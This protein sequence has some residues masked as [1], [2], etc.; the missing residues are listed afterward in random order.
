MILNS[1]NTDF[2]KNGAT[3]QAELNK[4]PKVLIYKSD[5]L[6]SSASYAGSAER[7][8]ESEAI[9]PQFAEILKNI[10][11]FVSL[12]TTKDHTEKVQNT[13]AYR[14]AHIYAK[15]LTLDAI[16]RI[17]YIYSYWKQSSTIEF[18]ECSNNR[19]SSYSSLYKITEKKL[20]QNDFKKEP[21][22]SFRI[23]IYNVQ[24][25]VDIINEVISEYID[26]KYEL[27]DE[28]GTYD[29]ITLGRGETLRKLYF[30]RA[31]WYEKKVKSNTCTKSFS[32]V[33][34]I[35]E[36]INKMI[37]KIETIDSMDDIESICFKVKS[38]LEFSMAKKQMIEIKEKCK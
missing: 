35:E 22:G 5:S 9:P 34:E 21:D 1:T 19:G 18:S 13:V 11:G 14:N 8:T 20:I 3:S 2:T 27:M 37:E 23:D 33:E 24:K 32:S 4:S 10:K 31:Y 17:G 28:P 25:F 36:T 7:I 6:I 38:L 12:G 29:I 16:H 15:K 30:N 26:D